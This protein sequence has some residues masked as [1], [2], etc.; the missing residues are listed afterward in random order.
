[1]IENECERKLCFGIKRG[2][3][4]YKQQPYV[5][6]VDCVQSEPFCKLLTEISA[7]LGAL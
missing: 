7:D 4:T 2:L 1:M 5:V 6:N 3:I